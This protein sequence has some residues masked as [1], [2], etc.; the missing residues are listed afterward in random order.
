MGT[1]ELLA[2]ESLDLA[3]V[4]AGLR[5]SDAAGWNQN[6]DDWAFF[7]GEG[8]A[9]GLRDNVGALI[10]TAAALPYGGEVGW[11]SMVLVDARHRHRGHASRLLGECVES[12]HRASRIPV[13]DATPAGAEVYRR[14]GFVAGFVFER[15]EGDGAGLPLGEDRS[16]ALV[17]ASGVEREAPG[18][19]DALIALDGSAWGI[20]RAPLLRGFLA[21]QES[22][23][24]LAPDASG[25]AIRRA[26]R[27]AAQI[28]PVLAADPGSAIALIDAALANIA[29]RT[30][31]DVPVHAQSDPLVRELA[32]RGFVRQRSFVRMALGPT[33]ALAANE[34]VF[35]LAGPEFG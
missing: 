12:L 31:I 19:V 3:D 1:S 7:V 14:G 18:S 25:F 4:E 27:R 32:K 17:V 33:R 15:W 10:A 8:D 2:V 11:I 6:A 35:A 13:L 30:F 26:G 20:D 34:R 24:W 9:F 22:S 23:G 29:G 28:G 5:L 16:D 21:R